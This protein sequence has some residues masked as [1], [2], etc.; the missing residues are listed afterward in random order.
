M[1]RPCSEKLLGGEHQPLLAPCPVVP[2][3]INNIAFWIISATTEN[4]KLNYKLPVLTNAEFWGAVLIR[5]RRLSEGGAYQRVE[6]IM[7]WMT[8][9]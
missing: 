6:L 9:V 4:L 8:M 1:T 7:I 3:D 2:E 5:G